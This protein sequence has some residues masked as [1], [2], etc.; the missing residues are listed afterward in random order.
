[1]FKN[2]TSQEVEVIRAFKRDGEIVAVGARLVLPWGLATEMRSG[3]KVTFVAPTPVAAQVEVAEPAA[4]AEPEPESE[5]KPAAHAAKKGS[6][7]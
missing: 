4:A 7:P 3:G 2:P 1:M 6:K 5:P